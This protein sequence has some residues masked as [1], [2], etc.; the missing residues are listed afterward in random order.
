MKKD[1]STGPLPDSRAQEG[2][3][4][5]FSLH[6]LKAK[7][8]AHIGPSAK[9]QCTEEN[10]GLI[11][12]RALMAQAEKE[13]RAK[14]DQQALRVAEHTDVYPF[15]APGTAPLRAAVPALPAEVSKRSMPR[16]GRRARQW[17]GIAAGVLIGGGAM[18]AAAL[19]G[20]SLL[21]E[22]TLM[23]RPALAGLADHKMPAFKAEEAVADESVVTDGPPA[24]PTA[25]ALPDR[26][27]KIGLHVPKAP[28]MNRTPKPPKPAAEIPT[29]QPK[30]AE[31]DPCRGDLMCAMQRAIE[32]KNK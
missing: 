18:A 2:S 8:E 30:P 22:S 12:L 19:G 28:V 1:W 15:G 32:K 3:S 23:A 29:A 5:L 26:P 17:G 7:A 6:E 31:V 21:W 10:S 13:E 4:A 24:E 16:G 27:A 9:G 25:T 14:A 20:G 11:D